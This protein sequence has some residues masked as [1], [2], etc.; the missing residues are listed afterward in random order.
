MPSKHNS[1]MTPTYQIAT[2]AER[3][4]LRNA[5]D[6]VTKN[7]WPEFMLHDPISNEYWSALYETFPA[8]QF[9]LFE[10]NSKDVAAVG[11][12]LP[13]AL[14]LSDRKLPAEGW[15]WAMKKGFED[16]AAGEPAQIQCAISITIADQYRGKGIS[17]QMVQAMKNIGHAHGFDA[18]IAPIRP[19]QKSIYPL[20]P[21]ERYVRWRRSD[22]LPFDAW[23]RVHA[24]LGA[25]IKYTCPKSMR[26]ENTV[27]SWEA[28][29]D[30]KFPESAKYVVPGALV[31]VVIDL[32][33]DRGTY[34]E[35]NVWM[36]HR[37]R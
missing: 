9:A 4:D 26:I 32:E 3:P 31:P 14:K 5:C 11:N 15:D 34:I 7:A 33:K 30:M 21:M 37:I 35:P 24:R 16:P 6:N 2:L 20:I 1:S 18:L 17:T 10:P 19:N 13:L 27:E 12:S 25:E 29:T 36:V 23:M 28:W 8:F 22:N